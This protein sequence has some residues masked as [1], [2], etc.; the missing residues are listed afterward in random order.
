MPALPE[1]IGC[2]ETGATHM[3]SGSISS[4]KPEN[5][6]RT[7]DKRL[8]GVVCHPLP[9]VAI[10]PHNKPASLSVSHDAL[11]DSGRSA[12]TLTLNMILVTV[13]SIEEGVPIRMALNTSQP[14]YS[15]QGDCHISPTPGTLY[16]VNVALKNHPFTVIR[17][18]DQR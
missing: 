2:N 18:G 16:V 4:K 17:F 14:H 10:A 11:C 12:N 13:T 5:D 3:P 1:F 9:E 8:A 6:D 7:A 15:K